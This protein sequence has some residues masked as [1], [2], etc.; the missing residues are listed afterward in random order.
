MLSIITKTH[1]SH[2]VQLPW[3]GAC[4]AACGFGGETGVCLWPWPKL[5]TLCGHS[6][7]WQ[8]SSHLPCS[9][10]SVKKTCRGQQGAPLYCWVKV[11]LLA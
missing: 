5:A 7:A 6:S 10:M 1:Q 3:L 4:G 8:S 11:G 9:M 2:R